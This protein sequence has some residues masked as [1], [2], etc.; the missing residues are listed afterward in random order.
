MRQLVQAESVFYILVL[1]QNPDYASI[2]GLEELTE[3]QDGE[4]L[5]LCEIVSTAKV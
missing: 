3:R 4:N 2:V 1:L 5:C